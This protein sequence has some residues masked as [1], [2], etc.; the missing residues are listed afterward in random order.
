MNTILK[1]MCH[2]SLLIHS[3]GF[4]KLFKV[5]IYVISVKVK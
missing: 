3:P 5:P 4:A 2:L 1:N